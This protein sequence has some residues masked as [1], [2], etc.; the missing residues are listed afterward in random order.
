MSTA[1]GGPLRP[2]RRCSASMALR[3]TI[4]PSLSRWKNW[5]TSSVLRW[6]RR[7]RV[8]L[9]AWSICL[10]RPGWLTGLRSASCCRCSSSL[11]VLTISSTMERYVQ[12]SFCTTG[13]LDVTS[14]LI[15]PT[16]YFQLGPD[17]VFRHATHPQRH[18]LWSHLHRPVP[19][20]ALRPTQ[21]SRGRL[22]LDVRFLHGVC[23]RWALRPRR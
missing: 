17:L 7:G 8:L 16:D 14:E 10:R 3:T 4:M 9:L 5:S 23:L 21:V 15:C 11:P 22:H 20:R 13:V 2:R 1:W 19:R 12:L 18:Q 6:R